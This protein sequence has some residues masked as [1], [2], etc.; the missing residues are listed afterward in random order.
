[1]TLGLA[2][3][4]MTLIMVSW[5]LGMMLGLGSIVILSMT[6]RSVLRTLLWAMALSGIWVATIALN[7]WDPLRLRVIE[8]FFD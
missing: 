5:P 2:H 4:A 3:D 1:M 6:R 8:W 7:R